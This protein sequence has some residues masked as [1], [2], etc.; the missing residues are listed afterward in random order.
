MS[1]CLLWWNNNT[2]KC[3]NNNNTNNNHNNWWA[4]NEVFTII[5][6][7]CLGNWLVAKLWQWFDCYNVQYD[8]CKKCF[9]FV[10]VANSKQFFLCFVEWLRRKRMFFVWFLLFCFLASS[11]WLDSITFRDVSVV[12]IFVFVTFF[13]N[14]LFVFCLFFSN[15]VFLFLFS[16]HLFV[17]WC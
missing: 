12:F 1:K 2:Y 10:L 16:F 15:V 13:L 11:R 14:F 8:L 17:W 3:N 4:C 6:L 9:F 5:F 7:R